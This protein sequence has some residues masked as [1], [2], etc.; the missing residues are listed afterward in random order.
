MSH[1]CTNRYML[2]A[3]AELMVSATR[4]ELGETLNLEALEEMKIAIREQGAEYGLP[5]LLTGIMVIAA[6]YDEMNALGER[7]ES[8][9]EVTKHHVN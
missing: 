8:Q 7:L 2:L 6:S 9:L 4:E 1:K 5:E 3:A